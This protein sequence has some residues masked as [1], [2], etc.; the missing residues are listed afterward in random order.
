MERLVEMFV[1]WTD[2]TWDTSLVHVDAD[3]DDEA[4]VKEAEAY[5]YDAFRDNTWPRVAFIGLYLLHNVYVGGEQ[6]E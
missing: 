1:A 3:L 5:L 4:A 6:N 2:H